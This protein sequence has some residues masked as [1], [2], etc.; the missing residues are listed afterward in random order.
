MWYEKD[1]K[2]TRYSFGLEKHQQKRNTITALKTDEGRITSNIDI[3]QETQK[4]Y[5]RL[6]CSEETDPTKQQE[7]LNNIEL[8]LSEAEK[9]ICES[10]VTELK[11][12]KALRSMMN[13]KSPGMDGLTREFY[14]QFWD[15]LSK[16]LTDVANYNYNRTA[17]TDSQ[18]RALLK[19][20]FK[21][22]DAELL[23]NWRPISLL[24]VDY[25]LIAKVLALRLRRV[26]PTVIHPD[27]TCGIPGRSIHE[28]IM[29]IRD[30]VHHTETGGQ[31]IIISLDYRHYYS[32][33]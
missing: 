19:L 20:L 26:L 15:R 1:E 5:E 29:K 31:V 6:Y 28:N 13:N 22:D 3:L 4:L 24:N 18:R 21:K 10:P 2:P 8:T 14:V 27:Q 17:M 12:T 30:V 11:L 32:P 16:A 23:K 25:K 9:E 33:S 7:F